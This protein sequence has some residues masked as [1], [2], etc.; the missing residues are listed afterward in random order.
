MNG[1]TMLAVLKRD[2][3]G[4]FSD[5]TGYVFILFFVLVASARA[6]VP[7]EF[8]N[9]NK[10][11][12]DL[13]SAWFPWVAAVFV[14]VVTMAAWSSER[15][16]GTEQLLLT[17]PALDHE[18][19]LAKFGGVVGIYT[20][21]LVFTGVCQLAV[22][23]YLGSPDLGLM[24]G[25]FLG[26][27]LIGAAYCALGLLASSITSHQTVAFIVGVVLCGG[28]ATLHLAPLPVGAAADVVGE[29]SALR[30]FESFTRGAVALEDLL[31][32]VALAGAGLYAN[33]LVVGRR[34]WRAGSA[35]GLH[36]GLRL[37][38]VLVGGM[39]AVLFVEQGGLRL[40]VTAA[41]MLALKPEA[42]AVIGAIDEKRPVTV[43]CWVSKE[44]PG[45]YVPTRDALLR[46]LKELDARGG[47]RVRAIIH[48]VELFS[49]EAQRAEKLFGIKP[50]RV[51]VNEGGRETA[52]EVLLGLAFVCGSREL[53]IPFFHKGLP[54]QYELTRAIGSAAA[55]KRLAVGVM[56]G[57]MNIFGGFDF[58]SMGRN[59]EWQV[60][61][62]LKKQYDV[63]EVDGAAP[64]DT[65]LAVLIVPAP[66]A[67]PQ[68]QLDRLTEYLWDGGKALILADPYLHIEL[69][70]SAAA[71]PGAGRNPFQQGP[72]ETPKGDPGPL[73]SAMGISFA[74]DRIVWDGRN[75]HPKFELPKEL[76][77]VTGKNETGA[78]GFNEEHAITAG[79]QELLLIFPGEL[80][81]TPA[82]DIK[83]TP[84]LH[85]SSDCGW[86]AWDE[87]VG[88]SFFGLQPAPPDQR[89]YEKKDQPRCLAMR[90]TG[91]MTA[92]KDS[93]AM[94][95]GV[96]STKAFDAVVV[97]D[98][99]LIS[100]IPYVLRRQ[101]AERAE[102]SYPELDNITFIANSIDA[103]AGQSDYLEL[104]KLRPKHRTLS[105]FEDYRATQ[106]RAQTDEVQKA[107]KATKEKLDAA[108]KRLDEKLKV[109][110]DGPGDVR[111]KRIRLAAEQEREQK[112]LDA[113]T[114]QLNDEERAAVRRSKTELEKNLKKE[115]T[116]LRELAV[117]LPPIPV[118]ALAVVMYLRRALR[119]SESTPAQRRRRA[120]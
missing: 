24:F 91:H 99:D 51:V 109:I 1:K 70:K 65:S 114:R 100:D 66:H 90:V 87:M 107:K 88:Q 113:E 75:P 116:R 108:R 97:A 34:H 76:V 48:E 85:T 80:A 20:V 82:S 36:G 46:M 57:G 117:L 59:P 39:A 104:R 38:S 63:R 42:R 81:A 54:V 33:A 98:L 78:S 43:E 30:R 111:E 2:L 4:F 120:S 19:V 28:V 73:L 40:D 26:Y 41:R 60:V 9:Q 102:E 18:L 105:R 101:A 3:R 23:E 79:L 93:G 37:A 49:D 77:F 106:D 112:R 17:L 115:K 12:L 96:T 13:L 103:L 53:T 15:R 86:H 6:F 7:E 61:A 72:P 62:D 71:P 31:Y 10:A 110:Q 22:L 27:W 44:M 58:Q 119:E 69:P 74:K 89:P 29:L 56:T 64:I 35:A 14:P 8:F 118:L 95:K 55:Q 47:D 11:N 52:A 16:Q 50:E 84:L 25:T 92:P 21:A 83:S 68:E 5:P 45:E 94:K 67:M 32:F